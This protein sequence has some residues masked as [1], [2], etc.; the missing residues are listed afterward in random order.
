MNITDILKLAEKMYDLNLDTV[1]EQTVQRKIRR[2][3]TQ[4]NIQ[5]PYKLTQEQANYLVNTD[6]RS[7]FFKKTSETNKHLMQDQEAYNE[8]SKKVKPDNTTYEKALSNLK[9]EFIFQALQK[10][11]KTTFNEEKFKK[12]FK[13]Y[14]SRVDAN[15]YALPGYIDAKNKLTNTSNYFSNF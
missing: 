1:Q 6:L 8:M 11:T 10:L 3:L 5:P 13:K 15:G 14:R 2:T 7:Y 9:S 12:D 4:K